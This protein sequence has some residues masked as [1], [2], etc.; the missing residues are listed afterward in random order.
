[1]RDEG[2]G[3]YTHGEACPV[4]HTRE[5]RQP[6]GEED[7]HAATTAHTATRTVVFRWRSGKGPRF[8]S[9]ER[10]RTTVRVSLVQYRSTASVSLGVHGAKPPN[11]GQYRARRIPSRNCSMRDRSEDLTVRGGDQA[12]RSSVRSREAVR[13]GGLRFDPER[14]TQREGVQR[15]APRVGLRSAGH[16]IS[17]GKLRGVSLMDG[18][19]TREGVQGV[20]WERECSAAMEEGRD[21][22][23]DVNA[24]L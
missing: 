8:V 14:R 11:I 6:V 21:V 10:Q 1:M 7:G 13:S 5:W 19:I 22:N 17:N 12:G 18:L 4:E 20:G 9:L 24:R 15:V 2:E 23:V 16:V 3:G